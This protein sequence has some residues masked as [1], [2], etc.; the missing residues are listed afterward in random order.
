M[1]IDS[2]TLSALVDEYLDT[3]VGGRIQDVIDTDAD[4]IGLEIYNDRQRHYLYISADKQ[5][6]RLHL[7]PD[8][9]RRGL[10]KP[11][12]IGLLMRRHLEGGRLI[13]ISQPQWERIIIFDVE[14]AEGEVQLILE[15]MPRRANLLLVR[16]GIILDCMN[17]VGPEDNRYRL[18]LPNHAYQLPPPMTDRANPF[19]MSVQDWAQILTTAKDPRVKLSRFLPSRVLGMSPLLASELAFRV[20]GN[21]DATPHELSPDALHETV[22]T[23]MLPLR[24]RQWRPGITESEGQVTAFATYPITHLENWR[25]VPTMSQALSEYYGVTIGADAY[26]EAKKPVKETIEEVRDRLRAKLN[27]LESGLRDETERDHLQ[28]SGELI[29]AYQYTIEQG[30]TELHA[31]YEPD[32]PPLT[33]ALDPALTPLENAQKYFDQYNRA[34]RAQKNV[35]ELIDETHTELA[36]LDQL[37]IDLS[38]ANNWLEI[39]DVLQALQSRGYTLNEKK[40]KRL[41]GGGGR[42]APL[43]IIHDGYI[44]WIGRNSR[45]NEQVTFK[46][47]NSEDLWLHARNV[48]GAHVVIR[49]DGRTIPEDL[50]EQAAA[51]AAHYSARRNDTKADV[52]VTRIKYV[53]KIKGAGAGMV[54]YRNERTLTV[55]P[56]SEEI[57]KNE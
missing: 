34:K 28:H 1:N 39:D 3:L 48:P 47:A 53:K 37:E 6:P 35:P 38:L 26:S 18:S 46:N 13:H 57:W 17:R 14:G 33:I 25:E 44:I 2:F 24:Q 23:L 40:V 8:K 36:F 52:D 56:H 54:T 31:Q 49:Y 50:I 45:Q 7:V 5:R 51:V 22:Q 43:R 20:T 19:E 27:S 15:P 41:G 11:S 29:L 16:D 42:S 9:L 32:Q 21:A 55:A 30:Q 12:Q 10:P 4:G